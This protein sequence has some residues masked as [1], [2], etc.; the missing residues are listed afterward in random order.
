M[1]KST[2]R[3][4]IIIIIL[5][6]AVVGYYAFLSNQEKETRAES[7]M[8]AVQDVLSRNLDNDY[9]KTPK[10]VLNYYNKIMRCYYNENCTDQEI[11]ALG[12]KARELYD[13]ELLEANE[14]SA[15]LIALRGDIQGFRKADRRITNI[16]LA[17]STSVKRATID[18]NSFATIQCTYTVNE[19]GIKKNTVETYLLRE[20]ASHRWKIYGW[21][22]TPNGTGN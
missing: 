16:A 9:P 12:M 22:T 1:K 6:L 11:D 15:Y 2:T 14:V 4:T 10:E 13:E 5:V 8:S 17:G 19:G 18:G 20:D 21:E 3:V 7:S